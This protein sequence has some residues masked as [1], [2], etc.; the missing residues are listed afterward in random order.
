MSSATQKF[1]SEISPH[2]LCVRGVSLQRAVC[3]CH[4]WLANSVRSEAQ[5]AEQPEL[6]R[7]PQSW[8]FHTFISRLG[9]RKQRQHG[10][11]THNDRRNLQT[12]FLWE[13]KGRDMGTRG[14][15]AAQQEQ[16]H[17]RVWQP[18]FSTCKN[19]HHCSLSP[20]PAALSRGLVRFV[21]Q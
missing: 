1:S 8:S 16:V 3:E 12:A 18:T 19:Q 9:G 5:R 15:L 20:S 7:L 2:L 17:G 4:V 11:H 13:L 10:L 14:R 6:L 21:T